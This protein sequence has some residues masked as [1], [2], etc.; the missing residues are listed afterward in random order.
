[1]PEALSWAHKS[2]YESLH[3]RLRTIAG[4]RFASFCRPV[5]IILLVT[6]NCNAKCLH[7]DIWK[8][9]FKEDTTIEEWK[10]LLS[11]LR[12]WLG[13]VHVLIS[14]GEAL[15]KPYTVELVAHAHKIGLYLEI[16][17]HGYWKDQTKIERLARA[18]PRKVT[19]SLDGMGEIHT[20]VRGRPNFWEMSQTSLQTLLRLRKEEKLGYTV[21]LKHVLMSY[22]VTDTVKLAK[23]AEQDGVEIFFQ[24]IEQ[25]YNT[26]DDPQWYLHSENWPKDIPRVLSNIRELLAM[27]KSGSSHIANSVEQL[28]AMLPYFENPDASRVAMQT[29][30]AHEKRRSCNALTTLQV[31]SN[32]DI[33][34]CTGVPPVGNFREKPIREIWES[35]PHFWESG[36]C[37]E[38]RCSPAELKQIIPAGS[39]TASDSWKQ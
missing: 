9:K 33:S 3:Y 11:D 10:V 1:M 4:G 12:N 32:G 7:C 8:N 29:H 28:E 34:V 22:N 24:A 13:P 15:M 16:L 5:S 19:M 18:N 26:P 2:L 14:G 6:E 35:R 39:L 31:Q 36:C 21:R 17:T 37:L 20:Q 25:N 23:F 27:K 30:S 38:T